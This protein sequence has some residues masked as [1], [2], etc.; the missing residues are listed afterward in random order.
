VLKGRHTAAYPALVPDVEA[1]GAEFVDGGGVVDGMMVSARAWPDHPSWMREF[2]RILR[3]RE[4]LEAH[5]HAA[6]A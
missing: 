1:A 4:P 3:E 6:V 5:H 2:V